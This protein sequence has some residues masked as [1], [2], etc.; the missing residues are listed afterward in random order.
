M[1]GQLGGDFMHTSP[2]IFTEK[3]QCRSVIKTQFV[4]TYGEDQT[5]EQ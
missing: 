1:R 2:T 5:C 4:T 3:I